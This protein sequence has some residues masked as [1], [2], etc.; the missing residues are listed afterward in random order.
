MM[1]AMGLPVS[2][3][4]TKDKKVEGNVDGVSQKTP[5]FRYRQYMNR[6]GKPPIFHSL[7]LG[8]TYCNPYRWF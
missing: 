7:A 4:S 3:D 8:L 1:A 5:V 6:K 2:F